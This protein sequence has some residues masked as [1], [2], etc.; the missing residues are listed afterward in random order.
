MPPK[1]KIKYTAV[2]V[3]DMDEIFSVI[4]LNHLSLAE[5]MLEKLNSRISML[6]DF[7]NM[8]SVLSDEEYSLVERGYRF[9]VVQPYLVFYRVNKDLIIISR[10]LHSR[11]DYLRDLF[12]ALE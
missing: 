1:S 3:D 12:T 4:S 6:S 2:A 5:V 11:R 8:G 9:I 10:I 7:P